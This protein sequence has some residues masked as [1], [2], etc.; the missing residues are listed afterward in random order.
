MS[1]AP[2]CG[3][4]RVHDPLRFASHMLRN[5]HPQPF[6]YTETLRM[7]PLVIGLRPHFTF[8]LIVTCVMCCHMLSA[9][10]DKA[11]ASVANM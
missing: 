8:S 2:Y 7:E 5:R 10:L 6:A 1:F 9:P 4:T 11:G 3:L